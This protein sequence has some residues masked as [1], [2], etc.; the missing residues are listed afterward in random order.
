MNK[1]LPRGQYQTIEPTNIF[2]IPRIRNMAS[3]GV[4][5]KACHIATEEGVLS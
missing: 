1:T 2:P 5:Q 3:S 4:L